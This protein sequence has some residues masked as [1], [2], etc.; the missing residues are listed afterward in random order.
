V[1]FERVVRLG[2]GFPGI[3]RRVPRLHD[4]RNGEVERFASCG[5]LLVFCW[6]G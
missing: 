5:V 4:V 1:E 6:Y 2:E 3:A